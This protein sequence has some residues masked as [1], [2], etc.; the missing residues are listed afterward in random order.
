MLGLRGI[1]Q[2]LPG[3]ARAQS[4]EANER[5]GITIASETV[6]PSALRRREITIPSDPLHLRHSRIGHQLERALHQGLAKSRQH[7]FN[8][9][10]RHTALAEGG[11]M[12]LRRRP[13]L[14]EG[15]RQF[16]SLVSIEIEGFTTVG[17]VDLVAALHEERFECALLARAARNL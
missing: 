8:M 15:E 5:Q 16:I 12:E 1:P 17:C 7:L 14:N 10:G 2:I 4:F 3:Y 11:I 9:S 13:A 6:R